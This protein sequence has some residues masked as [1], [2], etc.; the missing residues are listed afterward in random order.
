MPSQ[1]AL[2]A[3]IDDVIHARA[4]EY[5]AA[6]KRF[7]SRKPKV[8]KAGE[9]H[10][11]KQI[12]YLNSMGITADVLN[13]DLR[14]DAEALQVHLAEVRPGLISRPSS[15][16]SDAAHR[17]SLSSQ[18]GVRTS[19]VPPY[20]VFTPPFPPS[21]EITQGWVFTDS[22]NLKI[23]A[24]STGSGSGWGAVAQPPPTPYDV[25]F[26]FTPAETATYDLTAV[27]AFHGF[28]VLRADDG[29]LTSKSAELS[30]DVQMSA[31]QYIDLTWQNFPSPI[32]ANGDNIDEFES[33]DRTIFFDYSAPLRQGD[34]VIVTTRI[35]LNAFA[36]GSGS[37]AEINFADGTA[38]YIQ[39]LFLSVAPA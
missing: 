18:L 26:T 24:D 27:F 12:K 36:N 33:Y 32:D 5:A 29:F 6:V 13:E 23:K 38:N 22:P 8:D 16:A 20:G 4:K 30:L 9:T 31:N 11:K 39:P 2:Q 25:T 7:E 14:K 37:Y 34:P 1:H 15:P 19:I 10:E 21:D 35:T 3:L 17:A 28:Y